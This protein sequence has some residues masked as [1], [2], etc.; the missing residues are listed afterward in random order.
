MILIHKLSHTLFTLILICL[1][2][3]FSSYAEGIKLLPPASGIY[4]TAFSTQYS[5]SNNVSEYEVPYFVNLTG[6]KIVWLNFSNDWFEGIV[7]PEDAIK[8]IWKHNVIPS[9][10]IMPWSG[11][12]KNDKT[13]SLKKILKGKFDREISEWAT[14]LR[15][16]SI[17][18]MIDFAAEPNGN[19][20]PW[21]GELNGGGKSDSYGDKNYPD[22]PEMYRDAYRRVIDI[23]RKQNALNV[24]WVF[25][26]NAV[27][28]PDEE[29][30]RIK[31]Y[32]PG[33]DYIDWLGMSAYGPQRW[34][35]SY[36]HFMDV[37]KPAYSEL[38]EL[39][40]T[41]PIAILEFGVAD[42]LPGIS[43]PN[44]IQDAFY[45]L[46]SPEFHRIKAI[47]WW[48]STWWNS[49][50]TI[51]AIQIDSSP[52]SLRFYKEA[53]SQPLFIGDYILTR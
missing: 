47:G 44:W 6:K 23:F 37:M 25:H 49:D 42:Y 31:Y 3:I 27:G 5:S 46:T 13:Y 7:F 33:D 41:K 12:D 29:W 2:S 20:F 24:T 51:S 53:V 43:K 10:R 32:Y 48:H 16:T 9:V 21:C 39:S 35:E 22:G 19:W 30:N 1:I 11:Y 34:G 18:V 26:V 4:H 52:E 8:N 40:E 15:E 45:S 14:K 36:K 50:G 38:A 17:P 28:S